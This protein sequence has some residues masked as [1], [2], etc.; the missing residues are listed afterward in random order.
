MSRMDPPRTAGINRWHAA[1]VKLA[2]EAKKRTTRHKEKYR[3]VSRR[4]RRSHHLDADS[5][6]AEIEEEKKADQK[7]MIIVARAMRWGMERD[8]LAR[9]H[10]ERSRAARGVSEVELRARASSSAPSATRGPHR[11]TSSNEDTRSPEVK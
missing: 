3:A 2:L 10:P 5:S 9:A 11:D 1:R 7:M 6:Q 8:L 4:M